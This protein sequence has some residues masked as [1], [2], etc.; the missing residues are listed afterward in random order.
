M[1]V[2]LQHSDTDDILVTNTPTVI[3]DLSATDTVEL[4]GETTDNDGSGSAIAATTNSTF[5][6]FKIG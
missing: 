2:G 1:T 3:L 6:G 4:Y 5:W